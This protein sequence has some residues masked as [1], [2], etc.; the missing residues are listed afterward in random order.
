MELNVQSNILV[1][2][3]SIQKQL[4]SITF[5]IKIPNF[6]SEVTLNLNQIIAKTHDKS[7]CAMH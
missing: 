5:I 4:N 7:T 1:R 2:L 3:F 6:C